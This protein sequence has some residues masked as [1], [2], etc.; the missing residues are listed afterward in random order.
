MKKQEINFRVDQ[1]LKNEIKGLAIK[2]DRS[3]SSMVTYIIKKYIEEN[4]LDEN[5][6]NID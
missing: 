3:L 1:Q 6:K 4:K 2:N 5:K